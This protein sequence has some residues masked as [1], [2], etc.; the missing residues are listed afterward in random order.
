MNNRM[1]KIIQTM[2]LNS[3][4]RINIASGVMIILFGIFYYFYGRSLGLT[5]KMF[6]LAPILFI[7]IHYGM[8]IGAITGFGLSIFMSIV[9]IVNQDPS[10]E[11]GRAVL[12][13]IL[14]GVAGGTYGLLSD[15]RKALKESEEELSLKVK[16]QTIELLRLLNELEL[17]YE[18]TLEG[19]A[20]ALELRD[21]ET[22]GHSRRVT[23]LAMDFAEELGF[24]EEEIRYICYGSLLHDIGKMGIPDEILNKSGSLNDDEWEIIKQHP[25][26]AYQLLKDIQ[27]LQRAISIPHCH[28]ENWD[29][30][31][32]PQGLKGEEIPIS[33]RIFSIIDNWDA[34]TSDRPYR[35]AW[36]QSKTIEYLEKQSGLKFDPE[37]VSVFIDDVLPFSENFIA[38]NEA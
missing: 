30:S 26:Y 28:H 24:N 23:Q 5:A 33:A 16:E 29:G 1:N 22:E 7:A 32:Y 15:Q 19:W 38:T 4:K 35:K 21:K 3:S 37:I 10:F 25:T 13:A 11:F 31:G 6:V 8:Q 14:A 17:A 36:S 34:L 18:T 20:L 9:N 12:I 2:N 27:Y